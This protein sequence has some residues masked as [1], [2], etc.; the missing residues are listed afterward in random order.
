[1][2]LRK[3]ERHHTGEVHIEPPEPPHDEAL[4]EALEPEVELE[5]GAE[6]MEIE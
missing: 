6:P 3:L 4:P 5:D 1:M 2:N